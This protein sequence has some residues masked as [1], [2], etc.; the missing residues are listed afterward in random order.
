MTVYQGGAAAFTGN[1]DGHGWINSTMLDLSC[2]L[3]L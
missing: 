3:E 1:R 2:R